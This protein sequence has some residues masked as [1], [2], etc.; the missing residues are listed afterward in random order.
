KVVCGTAVLATFAYMESNGWVTGDAPDDPKLGR[1]W[2]TELGWQ[3][4]SWW[5]FTAGEWGGFRWLAP[6]FG[7][8]A[9]GANV[10]A[11]GRRPSGEVAAVVVAGAL[12]MAGSFDTKAYTRALSEWLNI[13]RPGISGDAKSELFIPLQRK[14]LTG[15]VNPASLREIET[16][17]DPEIRRARPSGAYDQA[18]PGSV[19]AREL[20]VMVRQW[21][22]QIPGLS[23]LK[24]KAGVYL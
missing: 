5:D 9:A 15:L 24:D 16:G 18:G 20:D 17:V 21:M 19:V 12:A 23:S 7:P 14:K 10:S 22:S 8:G 13:A 2:E 6:R 11:A 1:L 4:R 3:P